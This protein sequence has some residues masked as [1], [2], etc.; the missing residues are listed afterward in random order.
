MSFEEILDTHIIT[1]ESYV[2]G[3]GRI[4]MVGIVG[5]F[6]EQAGGDIYGYR[7]EEDV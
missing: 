3:I 6:P 5:L 7:V 2:R 1:A 4:T